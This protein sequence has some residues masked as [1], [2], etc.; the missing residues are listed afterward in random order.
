MSRRWPK[1]GKE[2]SAENGMDG[3][4]KMNFKRKKRS[5]AFDLGTVGN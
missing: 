5:T 4:L 1:K 2:C 3:D